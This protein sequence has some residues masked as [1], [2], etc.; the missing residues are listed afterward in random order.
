MKSRFD[1]FM[2]AV[3]LTAFTFAALT[4][5]ERPQET[6]RYVHAVEASV[7]DAAI[8]PA[9]AGDRYIGTLTS[10]GASVNNSTTATPFTLPTG[11]IFMI[12]VQCDAAAYVGMGMGSGTTATA[13]QVKVLADQIYDIR[14]NQDTIA[15]FPVSGT[16]NC[17]V[18]HH[19]DV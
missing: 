16:V 9:Q 6:V 3:A 18:F 17:R 10:T 7:F 4:A 5:I 8:P 14:T 15:M 11:D 19:K 2:L 1:R 12:A 13:N